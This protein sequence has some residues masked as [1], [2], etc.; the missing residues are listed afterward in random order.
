MTKLLEVREFDKITCNPD[1]KDEYAYLPE[2]IFN[3]LK[4]FIHVFAADEEH[5]DALAFLKIGFRR[6]VGYLISVSNYVGR[7]SDTGAP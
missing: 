2:K 3:D 1:F 6:N 7:L 4:E 5:A